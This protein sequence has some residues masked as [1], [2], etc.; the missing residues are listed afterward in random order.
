MPR[1]SERHYW[2]LLTQNYLRLDPRLTKDDF[3]EAVEYGRNNGDMRGQKKFKNTWLTDWLH[4]HTDRFDAVREAEKVWGPFFKRMVRPGQP[5][6]AGLAAMVARGPQEA[7][8]SRDLRLLLD[9][10]LEPENDQHGLFRVFRRNSF[11]LE[12]GFY[13][14]GEI[15]VTRIKDRERKY[16]YQKPSKLEATDL[17]P[18]FRCELTEGMTLAQAAVVKQRVV[19]GYPYCPLYP[20]PEDLQRRVDRARRH[21]DRMVDYRAERRQ[22]A[23]DDAATGATP[24]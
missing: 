15:I 6:H 5:W 3:L 18:T 2:L 11:Y 19:P 24:N 8:E 14:Y 16:G 1:N 13:E 4:R 23:C 7:F 22:R 17:D 10:Y 21:A 12:S 9:W 20:L